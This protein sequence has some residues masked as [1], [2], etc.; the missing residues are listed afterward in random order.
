MREENVSFQEMMRRSL[1][2]SLNAANIILKINRNMTITEP[3]GQ[4]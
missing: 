2:Q 3:K 1:C 4:E